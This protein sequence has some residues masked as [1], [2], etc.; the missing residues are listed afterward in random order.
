[1]KINFII[2]DILPARIEIVT[3]IRYFI[4]SKLDQSYCLEFFK[5]LIIN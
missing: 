1:L 3:K 2:E 4:N 5:N